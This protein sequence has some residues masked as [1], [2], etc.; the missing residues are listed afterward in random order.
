M[1]TLKFYFALCTSISVLFMSCDRDNSDRD[2]DTVSEDEAVALV[3]ESL[4]SEVYGTGVQAADAASLESSETSKGNTECGTITEKNFTRSNAE[5]ATVVFDHSVDYTSELICENDIP[6]TYVI[7]FSSTGTY[8]APRMDSDD[9]IIYEAFL[10]N[11]KN[12]ETFYTYNGA[13]TRNGSQTTRIAGR[14]R[15]FESILSIKT[16]NLA[17]DK[18]TRTVS[19]GTSTFSLTGTTASG[20]SF[21]YTGQVTYLGNGAA[22][23]EVNG[24]TYDV[25]L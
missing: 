22:Q 15:N 8:S 4:V 3:Q 25:S 12:E 16:E 9:S 2:V 14:T 13:F 5:G 11:L 6:N 21:S 1:K 17:I 23:I 20:D 24:N 7:E 10:T 18:Q 19:G